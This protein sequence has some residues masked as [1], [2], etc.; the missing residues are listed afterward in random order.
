MEPARQP[1]EEA[2]DRT[3]EKVGEEFEGQRPDDEQQAEH[4]QAAESIR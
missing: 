2:L 4:D 1:A 3:T